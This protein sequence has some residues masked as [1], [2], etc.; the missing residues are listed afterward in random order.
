MKKTLGFTL[1]ELMV[2]LAVGIIILG[3]GIPAFTGL[4]GSNRAT[5]YANEFVSALRLARSEAVKRGVGVKVCAEI[6]CSG[7]DWQNGWLIITDA[8]TLVRVWQEPEG[9]VTFKDAP[10]VIRFLPSGEL[11]GQVADFSFQL[12]G[13]SGEQARTISISQIGRAEATHSACF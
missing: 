5:G 6:A 8:G 1:V 4:M 3:I 2:A 12:E 9:N 11:S 13:C 7:S 10:A